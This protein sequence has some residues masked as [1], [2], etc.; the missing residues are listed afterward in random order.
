MKLYNI[1][2]E[3]P[4]PSF[5]WKGCSD[6]CKKGAQREIPMIDFLFIRDQRNRVK[7]R[8]WD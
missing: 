3:L 8:P 2:S 4:V 1:Y 6:D 5:K 7:M